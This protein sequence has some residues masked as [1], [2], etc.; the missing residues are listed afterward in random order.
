NASRMAA[1]LA[2]KFDLGWEFPGI[3]N[4][5]DWVQIRDQLKQRRPGLQTLEFAS[6]VVGDF[7]MR[8]DLPPFNDA[9]VRQAIALAVDRQQIIAALSEGSGTVNGPLPSALVD[10]AL[11]VS[12]LGDGG[13]CYRYD[14]TEAKRL[15]AAAGHPRGLA[16][17]VC[18]ATYGSTLLVDTMQVLLK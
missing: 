18:F 7:Q 8:T 11:P 16:A 6:N 9:R 3:V 4:R 13:T 12:Q 1:F 15:L 10:W 17:S 14:P 2:G 5:S